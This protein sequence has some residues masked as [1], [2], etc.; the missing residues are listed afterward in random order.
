[1]EEHRKNPACASCHRVMDPIG[2]ALDNF[3]VTGA[4][5]IKDNGVPLDSKGTL[6][7]GTQIDGAGRP[8][9]GAA[10]HSDVGDPQLHR[11]PD[12]LRPRPPRRGLRPA[13]DPRDRARTRRRTATTSRRSSSGS[14]TAP[15]S[16]WRRP[17]RVR[18]TRTRPNAAT[19]A[20]ERDKRA[21][22]N[23]AGSAHELPHAEAHFPPRVPK[24]DGRH[25]GAAVPRRDGARARRSPARGGRGAAAKR[26]GWSRSRWCT[27]RPAARDRRPEEPLG[28]GRRS[29][30]S[31]TCRPSSLAPL[32]PFKDYLTIVSNTD[33][34]KAEAFAPP[35]I[36]GD[37]FRSSA[38]F[39]TQSHPKQT[40]G[41]DLFVGTSIDQY[42]AQRFG[43]DTPIP[44]MQLCIETL[45][46]AGGCA[47]GYACVY[48]DTISWASPKQPLPMIRDPRVAFDQLFGVGATA[49]ERAAQPPGRPEHPRLDHR[50]GGAAQARA[51]AVGPRSASTST[52]TTSARS[53][54]ASRRSRRATRSGERARCPRRRSACPT[55][56]RST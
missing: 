37:H 9:A 11:E 38:V 15:R 56:S 18:T 33:V 17:R 45:D 53:S 12:G 29:A 14:S 30:A 41:S 4:W 26:R 1:M 2:L 49:E 22:V 20:D 36:G 10:E 34:R 31:S 6:Y 40:Q 47:Y 48:T 43:Q 21:H 55:R 35:E 25:P 28:A 3:D 27:A 50:R 32:E 46:Q 13:D 8:A 23:E 16:R 5:R 39:L 42:Y 19:R 51:R 44:S 54:A 24:G 7:D 52:S